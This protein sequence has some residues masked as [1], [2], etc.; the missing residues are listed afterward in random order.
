MEAP[1]PLNVDEDAIPLSPVDE[2][3]F[4]RATGAHGFLS[5]L[6]RATVEFE[7]RVFSCAEAAYQ[8][9]KP[10]DIAVAE[11]IVSAPKPHLMAMAAHGLFAFDV[12]SDWNTTRVDRM[13][14]VLIAKFDQH[15]DLAQSLIATGVAR[16]YE[17]S[18]TDPF[19]GTGRSGKGKNMLGHLLAECRD[20]INARRAL[21]DNH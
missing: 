20:V 14:R 13:R 16:L 15:D 3:R 11:W 1:L 12:K 9:G 17:D 5:N 21:R 10:R 18:H 19:W 6:Y 8:Y 4:Y 2:I 7:G